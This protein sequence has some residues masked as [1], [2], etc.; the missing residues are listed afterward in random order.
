MTECCCARDMHCELLLHTTPPTVLSSSAGGTMCLYLYPLVPLLLQKRPARLLQKQATKP[1]EDEEVEGEEGDEEDS[2]D[3]GCLQT[4]EPLTAGLAA[5]V[6][7]LVR[8]GVRLGTH[9]AAAARCRL[10]CLGGCQQ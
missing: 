4:W 1:L 8:A 5:F 10:G 6:A 2:V 9:A 3:E 7:E